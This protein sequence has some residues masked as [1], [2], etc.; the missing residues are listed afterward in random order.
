LTAR[1]RAIV[2]GRTLLRVIES[3]SA[4]RLVYPAVREIARN[5]IPAAMS[6]AT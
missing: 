4:F 1:I 6:I 5:D 2:A 3:A